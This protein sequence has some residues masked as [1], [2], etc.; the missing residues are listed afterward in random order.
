MAMKPDYFTREMQFA[1]LLRTDVRDKLTSEN[2]TLPE[3]QREFV[4]WWL[5]FGIKEF[6]G[7]HYIT[8][9]LI[10][11]ARETV[12]DLGDVKVTRIMRYL[13]MCVADGVMGQADL[14]RWYYT[15]GV[16]EY[17]LFNYLG[18]A[19][20][21]FLHQPFPG[22]LQDTS[23]PLTRLM[24]GVWQTRPDLKAHYS[25]ADK[26]SRERYLA[27]FV[28]HGLGQHKLFPYITLPQAV[29]LYQRAPMFQPGLQPAVTRLMWYYW[30]AD[31]KVNAECDL[32]TVAG[33]QALRS[34][35]NKLLWSQ[36]PLS[37]LWNLLNSR[38]DNAGKAPPIHGEQPKP[39]RQQ[40]LEN[41][42]GKSPGVNLV[43]YGMGE[44][45]IGEDVRMMARALE[46]V[47][48][49]FCIL[50]RQPGPEIRQ[51]DFSVVQHFS[52]EARY[53]ITIICMTAFDTATL[54][55]DRP[56]LFI[57][58]YVVGFWPWELPEWPQEWDEVYTLV[59]EVW[60]SSQYTR[61]AF[62]PRS[63]VPVL[64]VP[65]AVTIDAIASKTRADFDLPEG[66]F[67]YL[68]VFDFM[69][70]PARK[71][72]WACIKA[73]RE[74]FPKGDEPVNLVM[75]VSN[76]QPNDP[77]W[78]EIAA[79]LEADPRILKR[80]FNLEKSDVMALMS[81]CDAYVSLHR[82]EGFGR[83][84][85]EAMLLGKP[86]IATGYSGNADFLTKVTGFPVRY[87]KATIKPND[88]PAGDGQTWAEPDS[89]H[90]AEQ[91]MR[92]FENTPERQRRSRKGQAHIAAIHGAMAVGTTVRH[93]LALLTS[94]PPARPDSTRGTHT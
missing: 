87:K 84:M 67:L 68:F 63:P 28:I 76:V 11:V 17:H 78:Q 20:Y 70:Y 34:A 88:Y 64:Q 14:I 79:A 19:D 86:V 44:L 92:V 89:K 91:L 66:R 18:E 12:D 85:A 80:E 42:K 3:A 49:D 22:L 8:P 41:L 73:F 72:P 56:D 21:R 30:L 62:L 36:G 16:P 47:G 48:V 43:G 32:Q 58:T 25:L 6:P 51:M 1:W 74:A 26:E 61:A 24:I 54:W 75:K 5:L 77:R 40:K 13:M 59:D 50:N 82:A 53:P 9:A 94:D 83:T 90:A 52:T 29:S 15:Y 57:T 65:M 10:D 2:A 71:N 7:N 55:L 46:A 33:R 60:A 81:V 27:W 93:R 37:P 31:A 38:T 69:S 23:L 4:A 35:T 45:G 39:D